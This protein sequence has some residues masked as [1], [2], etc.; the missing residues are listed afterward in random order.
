MREFISKFK[1]SIRFIVAIFASR[2]FAFIY[3]FTGTL[4]QI[5]HTYFLAKAISS[6]TGAFGVLQATLL[7]GFIS[8]SLLY[9]V[10]VADKD[11]DPKEHRRDIW[12]INILMII[13]IL[14]NLYYYSRHLIIDAP[15]VQIY[16]FIFATIIS[17]L[18][19]VTIKLYASKIR[20]KEWVK[21]LLEFDQDKTTENNSSVQTQMFDETKMQEY[22]DN[23][24][25]SKFDKKFEENVKAIV[26][27]KMIETEQDLNDVKLGLI[28]GLVDNLKEKLTTE[29]DSEI[30]SIFKRNQELF[31]KQFENKCQLFIKQQL[32]KENIQQLNFSETN[33]Q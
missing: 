21:D 30:S 8:S 24:L 29:M 12:A 26:D 19:P 16:D 6:F 32:T 2:E 25:N 18:I 33:N 13:E 9:F 11:D 27:G 31:M 28:D 3:A 23:F 17:S 5:A 1:S 4:T 14:I 10:S 15:K 22:M 20:A 7:S